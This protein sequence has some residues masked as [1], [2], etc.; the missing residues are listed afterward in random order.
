MPAV[1]SG[2][3]SPGPAVVADLFESLFRT[4]PPESCRV[5]LPVHRRAGRPEPS[6]WV[7]AAAT[8]SGTALRLLNSA[9]AASSGC[10]SRTC[11]A[12]RG[13]GRRLRPDRPGAGESWRARPG[14]GG[15]RLPGS[16]RRGGRPAGQVDSVER[17]RSWRRRPRR[18]GGRG[19]SATRGAAASGGGGGVEGDA[20]MIRS[21]GDA[22]AE[23]ADHAD[24]GEDAR[25][26][27]EHPDAPAG[28]TSAGPADE[29]GRPRA[30]RFPGGA[31]GAA[32][33]R[34]PGPP[35][36]GSWA[37]S[38][39]SAARRPFRDR[40]PRGSIW[41]GLGTGSDDVA[42]R[43]GGVAGGRDADDCDWTGWSCTR[44]PE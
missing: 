28:I 43:L 44:H 18:S 17:H 8:S 24:R 20:R 16:R 42:R 10:S 25:R 38:P 27:A 29:G 41:R 1:F 36:P 33:A 19:S 9:A 15:L 7:L 39:R 35:G 37:L 40:V 12:G 23:P 14:R 5:V 32:G 34:R 22:G 30:G 3:R 2:R 31:G 4:G 11:V 21:P 26:M 13:R 6:E